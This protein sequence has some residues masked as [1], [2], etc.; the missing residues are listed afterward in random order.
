MTGDATLRVYHDEKHVG[1]LY[2][3]QPLRFEYAP[4]WLE[5]RDA[6]SLYA[7]IATLTAGSRR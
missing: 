4:G 5:Y 7:L 6:V 2:D 3:T 1:W